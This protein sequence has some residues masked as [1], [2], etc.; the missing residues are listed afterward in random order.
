MSLNEQIDEILKKNLAL[1]KKREALIAIGLKSADIINLFEIYDVK[2]P[3]AQRIRE[4]TRTIGV[5]IECYN[6]N[7]EQFI[8]AVRAKGVQIM[9]ESYNH[10][11]K[12]HYKIVSDCS[13]QGNNAIECVSPVLS[14]SANG[15]KSLKVVCEAL[16]EVG[17]KVNRTTGLHVHVGLKN[18]DLTHYKNLFINYI[19]LEGVI[20]SFMSKSR[21]GNENEYCKSLHAVYVSNIKDSCS[22]RD[23]EQLFGSRYFKL[24]PTSYKKHGTIEFRQHQGT[25]DFKKITNWVNFIT[26]FV[27]WSNYNRIAWAVNSI[28]DIEFLSSKEKQ[29]FINR[30]NELRNI[31]EV[32]NEN[33]EVTRRVRRNNSIT[34]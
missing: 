19:A 14:S 11:T 15:L 9:T 32:V 22:M 1:N 6:V 7:S 31:N 24:N 3:R 8:N 5:E 17:A 4:I 2:K 13:I 12:R 28:N 16:N 33:N 27:N 30:A 23:I 10:D 18:I 21:R 25:T 29:Y 26:K 20:D 34:F